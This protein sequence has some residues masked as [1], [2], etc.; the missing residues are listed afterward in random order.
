VSR[1]QSVREKAGEA[2]NDCGHVIRR[3]WDHREDRLR[4]W[5]WTDA[6]NLIGVYN[7][8][9]AARSS[10]RAWKNTLCD[11]GERLEPFGGTVGEKDWVCR[12]CRVVTYTEGW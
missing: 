1:P 5:A 7:T 9:A 12:R 8:R 2:V 6:M 10:R 11:C 3:L 4:W